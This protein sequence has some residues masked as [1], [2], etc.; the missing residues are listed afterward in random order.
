MKRTAWTASFLALGCLALGACQ[1]DKANAPRPSNETQTPT[2]VTPP[3]VISADLSLLIV[4]VDDAA[5][6]L[7]P[8]LEDAA[9]GAELSAQLHLLSRALAEGN[10]VRARGALAAARAALAPALATPDAAAIGLALDRAQA[11]LS[12]AAVDNPGPSP[13]S[14][15]APE[16]LR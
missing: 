7:A 15:A 14:S 10:T 3:P 12:D 2:A 4:G 16:A 8:A 6:R 13:R 5:E 11:L 9:A 1:A